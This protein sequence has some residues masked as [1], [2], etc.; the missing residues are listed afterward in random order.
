M[1]K[2]DDINESHTSIYS[3]FVKKTQ[4][5]KALEF[6]YSSQISVSDEIELV[7]KLNNRDIRQKD[8]LCMRNY[9]QL[10]CSIRTT[11]KG[12][13]YIHITFL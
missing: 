7:K 6:Y 4:I 3:L 2:E 11:Y 8:T 12:Y 9:V 10:T 13:S 1:I 5:L